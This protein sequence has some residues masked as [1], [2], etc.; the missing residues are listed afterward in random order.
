M[1]VLCMS[2]TI[3]PGHFRKEC[4]MKSFGCHGRAVRGGWRRFAGRKTASR[5]MIMILYRV[6]LVKIICAIVFRLFICYIYG[7]LSI[8]LSNWVGSS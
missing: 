8:H 3:Q 1:Y 5:L 7:N 2:K 6:V 4:P